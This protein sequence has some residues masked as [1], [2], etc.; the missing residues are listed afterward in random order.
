[1]NKNHKRNK[2]IKLCD[3]KDY[4]TQDMYIG[5]LSGEEEHRQEFAGFLKEYE[6]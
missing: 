3:G 1:M 4:V 6:K 5:I 2:R